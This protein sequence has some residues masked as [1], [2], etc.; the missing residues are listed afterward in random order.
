M[1]HQQSVFSAS[2]VARRLSAGP[3]IRTDSVVDRRN[4]NPNHDVRYGRR[5]TGPRFTDMTMRML[6]GLA[7]MAVLLLMA[8][9]IRPAQA[10]VQYCDLAPEN[11]Y[12]GGDGRWYYM[13]PGSR[14]HKAYHSGK[15]TLPE[16]VERHRKERECALHPDNGSCHVKLAPHKRRR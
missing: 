6:L 15:V 5:P 11:C 10:V 14:A 12:Y 4:L 1:H 13:A 7:A 8:P 9:G 3:W 16:I 2:P